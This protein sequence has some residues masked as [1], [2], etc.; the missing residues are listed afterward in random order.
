MSRGIKPLTVRVALDR[1]SNHHPPLVQAQVTVTTDA[2]DTGLHRALLGDAAPPGRR[3]GSGVE[4]DPDLRAFVVDPE[5]R[6][7]GG[8]PDS[9]TLGWLERD[10]KE[11]TG[12]IERQAGRRLEVRVFLR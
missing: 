3:T 8:W 9:A 7:Y 11:I 5:Q 12:A 6:F 4:A 2:G 10:T 1:V